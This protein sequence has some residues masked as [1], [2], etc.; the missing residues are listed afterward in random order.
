MTD[1]EPILQRPG[2]LFVCSVDAVRDWAGIARDHNPLHLDPEFAANSAFGVPIVHGHLLA[3]L[4]ADQLQ[5]IVGP[6]MT[7]SVRFKA[8]VPVGSGVCLTATR[9]E[10]PGEVAVDMT[11]GDLEPLDIDVTTD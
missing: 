10:R 11:C 7:F 2:H 3:C 8:P 6:A 4:V 1:H 9:G 5:P